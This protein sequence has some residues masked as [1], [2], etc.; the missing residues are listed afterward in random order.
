MVV[1]PNQIT[2][3]KICYKAPIKYTFF[4]KKKKKPTYTEQNLLD[5]FKYFHRH[6]LC[7]YKQRKENDLEKTKL[8]NTDNSKEAKGPKE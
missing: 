5:I 1:T 8:I 2:D 7:I 3:W 4:S 6:Y